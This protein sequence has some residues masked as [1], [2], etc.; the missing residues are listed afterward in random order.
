[1]SWTLIELPD[2]KIE[3]ITSSI[4]Y[5]VDEDDNFEVISGGN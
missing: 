5:I 4:H 2:G 3:V 1:M